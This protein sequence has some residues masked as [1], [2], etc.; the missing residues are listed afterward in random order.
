[1]LTIILIIIFCYIAWKLGYSYLKNRDEKLAKIIDQ[2]DI[3]TV[4]ETF[5]R[6]ESE[7]LYVNKASSARALV[8]KIKSDILSD[9]DRSKLIRFYDPSQNEQLN[10]LQAKISEFKKYNNLYKYD[11]NEYEIGSFSNNEHGKYYK[12]KYKQKTSPIFISP[13][14][15]EDNS[16]NIVV[17]KII[18]NSDLNDDDRNMLSTLIEKLNNPNASKSSAE[19]IIEI[20]SSYANVSSLTKD[21]VAFIGWLT[22]TFL[23]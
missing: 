8:A 11:H 23:S 19:K 14:V 5:F 21:V 2:L 3:K 12:L 13:V 18:N 4:I 20:L 16:T 1:M 17:N 22:K 9:D 10:S 6:F 7:R 15:Y